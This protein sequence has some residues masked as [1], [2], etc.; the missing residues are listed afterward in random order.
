MKKT[1]R[2]IDEQLLQEA[3]K[4]VA[5]RFGDKITIGS[6]T[7]LSG[8]DRRNVLMRITLIHESKNIPHSIILKQSLVEKSDIDDKEAFDRFARDWSGLEFLSDLEITVPLAP[9]FYGG[10]KKNRFVLME[11]LGTIQTSLIDL[12]MGNEKNKAL[13][14]LKRYMKIIG[15]IHGLASDHTKKYH[16][17]L[18]RINP[19]ALL[20]QDNFQDMF[21]KV[22][23]RI[24]QFGFSISPELNH[25]IDTIFTMAKNP[26]P[27]TTLMHG[28]IC[29]DN[30]FYHPETQEMRMIDFEW[31][32]VGNALLDAVVLRM[33]MPTSWSMKAFP[34]DVVDSIEDV[35][36]KELAKS[37]PAAHND[38]LYYKSYVAASAYWMLWRIVSLEDILDKEVVDFTTQNYLHLHHHWQPDDNLR[39][40]RNV[41]RLEAFIEISQKHG[42][43]PELRRMAQYI[44]KELKIRWPDVKP[45][46]LY[47]AFK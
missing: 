28:D 1:I 43:F 3:K 37:I 14:A 30:F 19:D 27:F 10:S 41:Y 39:K 34:Q 11:D 29:P 8:P 17:I 45:L 22:A 25:E 4:I 2:P 18:Q 23:G 35:Y 40:P 47:P 36:R 26:G 20:W 24:K 46:E 32:F 9:Q 31:S 13:G 7:Y 5:E 15:Q 12:L 42:F 38:T 21:S 16:K 6:A 33:C 44:L